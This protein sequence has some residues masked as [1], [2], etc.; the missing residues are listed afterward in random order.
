MQKINPNRAR[1]GSTKAAKDCGRSR[2]LLEMRLNRTRHSDR[3]E[4]QRDKAD[5][6]QEP[7]KIIERSAE[8]L[9]PLCDTIVFET[10]LL[11]MRRER[12]DALLR[13][14]AI[15]KAEI[16]AVMND[17]ARLQ[18]ICFSKMLERDVN[19]WSKRSGGGCFSRHFLLSTG[20]AKLAVTDFYEVARLRAELKQQALFDHA[21]DRAAEFARCA[22]RRSLHCAI[23]W[24]VATERSNVNEPGAGRFR[25]RRHRG[26]PNFPRLRFA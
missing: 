14:H 17:A 1:S 3:A 20:D 7:I 5:E 6:I 24:K 11:D 12:G 2:L 19:A 13:V 8:V 16:A 10:E 23:K 25:E 21:I 26:E 9:L 15:G 22:S 4:Q 18:K